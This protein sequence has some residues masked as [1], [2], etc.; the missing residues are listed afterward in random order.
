MMDARTIL[1]V[2]GAIAAPSL[3]HSETAKAIGIAIPAYVTPAH[4]AALAVLDARGLTGDTLQTHHRAGAY[5]NA[6][7]PLTKESARD[8]IDALIAACR[9]GVFVEHDSQYELTAG[10]ARHWQQRQMPSFGGQFDDRAAVWGAIVDEQDVDAS[11]L[12]SLGSALLAVAVARTHLI[13]AVDDD[14]IAEAWSACSRLA[15]EMDDKGY[16]ITGKPATLGE[17]LRGGTAAAWDASVAFVADAGA[18]TAKA[19]ASALADLVLGSPVLLA[20]AAF[21]AWRVFR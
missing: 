16:L 11:D 17:E 1:L 9:A 15:V 21:V 10:Q 5:Y 20:G 6:H 14:D 8:L 12:T 3:L 18:G 13:I 2:G 4:K 19:L 7:K